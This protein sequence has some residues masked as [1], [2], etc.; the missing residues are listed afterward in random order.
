MRM[1]KTKVQEMQGKQQMK[2]S[3]PTGSKMLSS[4]PAASDPPSANASA[5]VVLH[6]SITSVLGLTDVEPGPHGDDDIEPNHNQTLNLG[7][8][9]RLE[10]ERLGQGKV[11]RTQ[12]VFSIRGD[13][14]DKERAADK[15]RDF[16][17][18]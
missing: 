14:V 8:R 16:V 18:I 6:A 2:E 7:V 4:A 5:T 3:E 12:L 11:G 15:D 13:V 1:R 9:C 17:K 10:G